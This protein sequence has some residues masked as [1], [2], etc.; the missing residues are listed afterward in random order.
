MND[1]EFARSIFARAFESGT[2]G[3]PPTLPSIE[4]IAARGRQAARTRQGVYAASS[5]ALA[6]VVTAGV[7]SG[8]SLIGLGGGSGET[9]SA[10][11]PAGSVKTSGSATTSAPI[12]VKGKTVTQCPTPPQA[13]A[14][15]SLI[16][17]HLPAD[18]GIT[19]SSKPTSSKAS[20]SPSTTS[21][22]SNFVTS[23]AGAATA[24]SGGVSC[25]IL[26]DG[27]TL[28]E[29]IF[30]LT[31]NG[32]LQVEVSTGQPNRSASPS[33]G[34]SSLSKEDVAKLQALKS[35]LAAAHA[36]G[37]SGG[38]GKPA[39]GGTG[40]DASNASD[41]AKPPVS[42]PTPVCSDVKTGEQVC[43]SSVAKGGYTGFDIELTRTSPTPLRVEV[44]ASTPD[45]GTAPSVDAAQLTAVAEAIAAQY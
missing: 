9:S 4:R 15:A 24:T 14:W 30:A 19:P 12:T 20:S 44:A 7:V 6:G 38:S 33:T 26:P 39:P 17:S 5:V 16:K 37:A 3:E 27:S 42:A 45:T 21:S 25:V 43:A 28:M 11:Q 41:T 1:E 18:V 10:G 8:P 32:V 13:L 23:T 40:V 31:P 29:S 36:S 35:D 34:T 22:A 2:T